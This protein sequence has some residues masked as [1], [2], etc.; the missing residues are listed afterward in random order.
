MEYGVQFYYQ[1]PRK[2]RKRVVVRSNRIVWHMCED[3]ILTVARNRGIHLTEEQL[4]VV[5]R[6]VEEGL[7]AVCNWFMVVE[8]ALSEVAGEA[9]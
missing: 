5:A 2:K 4:D 7:S 3:D 6:Y 1:M 9:A 8:I